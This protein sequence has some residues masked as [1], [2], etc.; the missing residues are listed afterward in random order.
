MYA[1]AFFTLLVAS[2]A[3][4]PA[5]FK[6]VNAPLAGPVT[7]VATF[8]NYGTTVVAGQQP[9]VGQNCP[10]RDCE[11]VFHLGISSILTRFTQ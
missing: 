8:N 10:N 1:L 3:A 2:S 4:S 9:Q 6:R 5:L 11:Y 7:G